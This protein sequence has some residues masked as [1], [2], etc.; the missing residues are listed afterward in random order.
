[1]TVRFA[2]A[3]D[4]ESIAALWN[5]YI[6]E[7]AVT[8]ASEEKTPE[9][10]RADIARKEAVGEPFFVA[11]DNGEIIGLATYSQFRGG[12]GYA[13]TMEHTVILAPDGQRRGLGK[14]LVDALAAHAKVAGVHALIAGI[15]AENPAAIEFHRALGFSEVG[16]LPEVG[17]KFGR[18]MDL[19]LMQKIL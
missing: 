12:S 5:P 14:T 2:R 8:F 11:E 9:S 3:A 10:L 19:V 1:M 17:R 15:S 7:T 4:A 13:H 18:W 6:R 16:R